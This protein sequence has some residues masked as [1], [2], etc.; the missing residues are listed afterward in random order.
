MN[1]S[2]H[3]W[4]NERGENGCCPG[5]TSDSL[6]GGRNRWIPTQSTH[7]P[8]NLQNCTAWKDTQ[9]GSPR[10]DNN[11]QEERGPKQRPGSVLLLPLTRLPPGH[12]YGELGS[13]GRRQGWYGW[14]GMAPL[15]TGR[16]DWCRSISRQW[17]RHTIRHVPP[18]RAD[19]NS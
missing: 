4:W 10:H 17:R 18:T 14:S 11:S 5:Q 19:N 13:S 2:I 16:R 9:G 1:Q 7:D 12:K 6:T 3:E 8:Q 15:H